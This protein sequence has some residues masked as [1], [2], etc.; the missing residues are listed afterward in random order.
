MLV[1]SGILPVAFALPLALVACATS[2]GPDTPD[3]D[4]GDGQDDSFLVDGRVTGEYSIVEGSDDAKGVL[5]VA[6][7]MTEEELGEASEVNLY[8][9]PA[10]HIASYRRGRDGKEGTSDD[11]TIDTLVELDD[12]PWVGA[13]TFRRLLRY[14]R[15]NGYTA[16]PACAVGAE[17]ATAGELVVSPADDG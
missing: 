17:R 7:R 4:E 3:D 13:R 11:R 12:V 9:K 2:G 10:A 6:N 8:P 14:A 5:R 1:R 16:P 15:A